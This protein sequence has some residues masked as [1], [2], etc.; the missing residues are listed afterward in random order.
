MIMCRGEVVGRGDID[1]VLANPQ[2]PY[3]ETLARTRDLDRKPE[4]VSV[5]V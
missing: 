4:A 5:D 2:H 1:E 3:V